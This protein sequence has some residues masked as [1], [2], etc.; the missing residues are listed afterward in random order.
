MTPNRHFYLLFIALFAHLF[1]SNTP[2]AAQKNNAEPQRW[3]AA[4][5]KIENL[6]RK[7]DSEYMEQVDFNKAAEDAIQG[8]LQELDPHSVY[9]PA[10]EYD[11]VNEPLVGNFEGIGIRYEMLRDTILVLSVLE[12]GPSA[13]AGLQLG[14]RIIAVNNKVVA[15]TNIVEA[16]ISRLLRGP[17]NSELRVQ[18][19]RQGVNDILVYKIVRGKVPI[20]SIEAA[21]MAAPKVGYLKI[22]RFASN[23]M[24]EFNKSL[25][26]L[27]K[28]GMESLILDL[29]NNGGGYFSTAVELADEFL[30]RN[31]LI[32]YTEGANYPKK[33]YEATSK[34]GF[35]QGRLVVL[36][37]EN[38]A[39]ASEIVSGAIQ[40]W[41][42]GIIIGQRSF[43]KGLVQKPFMFSDSSY[44]RL[45]IARYF[46]PTGRSIQKPYAKGK[47]DY[48]KD[49]E[50]RYESGE[51]TGSINASAAP[52]YATDSVKYLTK[53]KNRLVYGG[54]GITPDV[55]VPLDTLYRTPY[56]RELV[57]KDILTRFLVNFMDKHRLS[58]L[59]RFPEAQDFEAG[60]EVSELMLT[61]LTNFA[62]QNNLPPD[63][64]GFETAKQQLKIRMKAYF[65]KYFYSEELNQR[66]LNQ[67]ND[68]YLKALQIITT[69]SYWNGMEVANKWQNWNANISG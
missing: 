7:L 39:S 22:N 66:I 30:N 9:I 15:G 46:T 35:E 23:T 26:T 4:S 18:V 57:N 43:G 13:K 11:E 64:A 67:Y 44:I 37:N 45:T 58:L 59:N 42:R 47:D 17:K 24:S 19:K 1:G 54:G 3:A 40:D 29:R 55:F 5:K 51:M 48:Y 60:F 53:L 50:K 52:P 65:A 10:D 20:P 69:D 32:V 12:D 8:I 49:I 68:T 25:K 41:D 21:Y 33:N 63:P 38:S 61:E 16:E 27:K 28:A 56:Y 2:V 36:I 31:Q 14:D 62:L 34:G 6:L